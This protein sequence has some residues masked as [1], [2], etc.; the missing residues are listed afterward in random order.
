MMAARRS[1]PGSAFALL[2]LALALPGWAPA[3]GE[4]VPDPADTLRAHHVRVVRGAL[5]ALVVARLRLVAGRPVSEPALR[6]RIAAAAERDAE[7]TLAEQTLGALAPDGAEP[8]A[9][10]RRIDSLRK[11]IIAVAGEVSAR[12]GRPLLEGGA[13][14]GAS[15]PF[16]V[17]PTPRTPAQARLRLRTTAADSPEDVFST[18]AGISRARLPR[19]KGP[20]PAR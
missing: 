18:T 20:R 11:R 5:R 10:D 6:A 19:E 1:C 4:E 8:G 15:S 3:A 17:S 12:L 14:T 7:L 16:A 2:V 9:F 13:F